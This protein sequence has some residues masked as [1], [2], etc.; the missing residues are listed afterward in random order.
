MLPHASHIVSP[1]QGNLIQKHALKMHTCLSLRITMHAPGN[2]TN[3][4]NPQQ[5]KFVSVHLHHSRPSS[6]EDLF[7]TV[8]ESLEL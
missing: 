6:G 4:M 1:L 2:P 7:S 8:H 3:K 5:N